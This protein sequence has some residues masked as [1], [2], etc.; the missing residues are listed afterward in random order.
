[1]PTTCCAHLIFYPDVQSTEVFPL[2][3]LGHAQ[4]IMAQVFYLA[5]QGL[6]Y[7]TFVKFRHEPLL[8]FHWVK[9]QKSK[10]A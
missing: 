3:S 7:D 10:R 2:A 9:A 1:M 5:E 6:Q 8:W 4:R